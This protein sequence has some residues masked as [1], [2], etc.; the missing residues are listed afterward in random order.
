LEST[1]AGL[2]RADAELRSA[3][4]MASPSLLSFGGTRRVLAVLPR[5]S[6][7]ILAPAKFSQAVGAPVT[8]CLGLDNS[9]ALCVE[10]DGLSLPHIA[11]DFIE[12][13]RDRAEFAARVHCRTDIA[14]TPLIAVSTTPAST[15]WCGDDISDTQSPEATCK[16]LVM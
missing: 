5:D 7:G 2:E 14:W 16:T 12:R 8:T 1:L 13:R 6:A 3:L 9:F 11:A 10:A 15:V 4:A